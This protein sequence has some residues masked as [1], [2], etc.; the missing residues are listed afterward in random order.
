MREFLAEVAPSGHERA[1]TDRI[2]ATVLLTDIV[3]STTRAQKLG[4]AEWLNQLQLHDDLTHDLVGEHEGRI[5]KHTGD[6]VL[7]VFDG[8]GR[9]L[10]CASALSRALAR[11]G[12]PIRAGMHTGEVE[13]RGD[14]IGGIGVHIAARV[15]AAAEAGEV[16]VSRTVKDLV[17]GSEFRFDDRGSHALKGVEGD[18][19][20]FALVD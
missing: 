12:L 8:P 15:M 11:A 14:D 3:E 9:G 16:L 19:Q 13:Q 17:V 5:V 1:Q 7:A 6:R 20:R 2:M 10:L 4:D 18:W